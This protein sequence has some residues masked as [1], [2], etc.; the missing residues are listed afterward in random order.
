MVDTYTQL[1]MTD[2]QLYQ[3]IEE[4]EMMRASLGV[5][6][7]ESAEMQVIFE[8]PEQGL[9]AISDVLGGELPRGASGEVL[10]DFVKKLSDKSEELGVFEKMT[11]DKLASND[12]LLENAFNDVMGHFED[13][14]ITQGMANADNLA[15]LRTAAVELM[16][17]DETMT[18]AFGSNNVRDIG[19]E[20][21]RENR[22]AI[23]TLANDESLVH[24]KL[25]LLA[26]QDVKLQEYFTDERAYELV[27]D[28]G[29]QEIKELEYGLAD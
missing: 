24:Q 6:L 4:A 26:E 11:P 13:K 22:N 17:M 18:Q 10:S 7:E 20:T 23:R 3:S 19:G 27:Y 28:H 14:A 21:H 8:D 12:V 9:N 2:D 25:V 1:D 15:E 5:S 16:L 29:E